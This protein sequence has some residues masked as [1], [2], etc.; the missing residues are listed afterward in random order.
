MQKKLKADLF[1]LK[2]RL[3]NFTIVKKCILIGLFIFGLTSESISQSS[4]I[5]INLQDATL[6]EVIKELEK[7]SDQGFVYDYNIAKK[8]RGINLNLKDVSIEKVLKEALKGSSL[9]Y[10]ISNNVVVLSEKESPPTDTNI[11][12]GFVTVRGKVTDEN[13]LPLPGATVLIKGTYKGI[14][15]N[16]EGFYSIKVPGSK[17]ILVFS[18]VGFKSKEITVGE[19]RTINVSL[20]QSVTELDDVVVIGYGTLEKAKITSSIAKVTAKDI[21]NVPVASIDQALQG[22][23]SGV[24]IN[25]SSGVPG[26]P[27]LI[28]IRGQNSIGSGNEP[29]FVIDGIP[30]VTGHQV[31]STFSYNFNAL[32]SAI[33][34]NDVASVEILKDAAATA[35]YGSRGSNGVVLITTKR[36]KKGK[37]RISMDVFSG[38][39][40][41]TAFLDVLNSEQYVKIK[42]EAFINDGLPVPQ[43][44]LDADVSINTDWQDEIFRTASVNDIQISA[45]GGSE[46]VQYYISGS[47][48]NEEATVIHS[49]LERVTLRSNLD[50]T[51]S[52]KLK[53]GLNIFLSREYNRSFKFNSGI[54][55]PV[56]VA[57]TATP[58][59]P[60]RDENGE[61]TDGLTLF[62]FLKYN[63]IQELVE[64]KLKAINSK[65]LANGYLNYKIF[66][67]LNFRTD[68]SVEYGV[69]ETDFFFPS[70][71]RTG[72]N[73]NGIAQNNIAQ[74]ETY[75]IEP[76]LRYN[77]IFNDDHNVNAILGATVF[78]SSG[79]KVFAYASNFIRDDLSTIS[80]AAQRNS[81]GSNTE[82]AYTSVFARINYDYKNKYL[83]SISGRRD[84]SSRFGTEKRYG[85]FW[86]LSG[87]WIFS[88]EKIF[89]GNDLLNFGKV[90]VSYGITG[91]DQIGNFVHLSRFGTNN[92]YGG[93]A[94]LVELGANNP[95]LRWE[96]TSMFD[97]GLE[98]SLFENKIN[99]TADYFVNKTKDLLLFATLPASTG[100]SGI[101]ENIGNTENKGWEFSLNIR[102]ISSNSFSWISRLN[103]SSVK[104][105]ITKLVTE[106]PIITSLHILK[107]GEAI[108]TFYGLDFEGVDPQTGNAIYRDVNGDG[109]ITTA[110]DRVVLGNSL[111]DFFGGFTNIFTY[112]GFTLDVFMQFVKNINVTDFNVMSALYGGIRT[113]NQVVKIL[114][115]WQKPGDITDIPRVTTFAGLGNNIHFSD[116]FIWDASYLRLKRITLAYDFP[117]KI[118]KSLGVSGL[119]IYVTATNLFTITNYPWQDPEV[120]NP[121]GGAN[122][123][124]DGNVSQTRTFLTGLNITF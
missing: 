92:G 112:K 70:T 83:L 14:T 97:L 75:N 91:N 78:N 93:N 56:E 30:V 118:L 7:K 119:R 77:K 52:E 50:I 26:A 121:R 94:G 116:R 59:I 17:S 81:G 9:R 60:V 84:G 16:K 28:R 13:G 5:N 45:N 89:E 76:T 36:G 87:G 54:G 55:D 25:S 90:R 109:V 18:F 79:R 63:P 117:P 105:K 31:P 96:Q 39:S 69:Y 82:Y 65:V 88:R 62:N 12:N 21:E 32:S 48:R 86:S 99:I 40:T 8:V 71:S 74:T 47:Y 27:T 110:E 35:I 22:Q 1:Y 72:S 102:N 6:V 38:F 2:K 120:G 4:K 114:D 43:N 24:L 49:K 41:P 107:E 108:S 11:K 124:A 95:E 10:S 123:L 66:P 23:A 111:P 80:S 58:F 57:T 73:S 103:I 101:L 100:V 122:G 3:Q 104:S 37:A 29:L 115:R 61:Y 51:A 33:N 15:T 106:D 46:N 42:S 85:N 19:Q 34:V 64:P 20:K 67:N 44:L 113:D 68:A 53:F 98:L